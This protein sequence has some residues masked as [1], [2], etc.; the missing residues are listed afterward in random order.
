MAAIQ[1][2]DELTYID[3]QAAVPTHLVLLYRRYYRPVLGSLSVALVL[4]FWEWASDSGMVNPLFASSPIRIVRA[5]GQL[6]AQ[7]DLLRDILVSGQ[8]FVLGFVLAIVVGIPLGILMGWYRMLEAVFDPFLNFLYATP[9]VALVPLF[10]IWLGIGVNSKIAIVFLGAV[11][12]VLI[13]TIIG[14]KNLDE[15]LLKAAAPLGRAIFRFSRLWPYLARCPSFW[16]ES[17]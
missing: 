8:E 16:A 1:E 11:F 2:L 14:M 3:S 13:N 17:D 12:A 10:I 15:S 9:R 7:G 4:V 6:I 5:F